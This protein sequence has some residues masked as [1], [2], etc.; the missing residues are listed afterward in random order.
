MFH[1]E[2]GIKLTRAGLALDFRRRQPRAFI[3]HAHF[4]HMARHE[5]ALCTPATGRLYQH[6]LGW[7]AGLQTAPRRRV[8]ELPYG[9]PVDFGGLRLT[10]FP[11]GHCL[12]S[13]ML[14]VE[15]GEKR[16]LY[17]G[18][19]KLGPSATAE[20]AVL[21][22][23]DVLIMESTF[24]RPQFRM[25]PR[26]QAIAALVELVRGTLFRGE[27]PVLH[28]YPMGKSQEISRILNDH[29]IGVLQHPEIFAITRVYQACGVELDKTREYHRFPL[30]G[31]AV[32]TLPKSCPRFRLPG[33]ER[34]V[35]IAVTGWAGCRSLRRLGVD[36]A[37]PLSDHAD[38]DELIEAV[39]LVHPERVFCTHGPAEFVDDL[40]NAGWDAQRLEWSSVRAMA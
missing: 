26:A 34:T 36:H 20:P 4:D 15:D 32:I 33:L 9:K 25:P 28:L 35:S 19:F 40:R 16:L 3:S 37:V 24:G 5:L 1:I 27:V 2:N 31:C 23:A 29:G 10:T 18:D 30:P 8:L 21:P 13:A 17:T 6:R 39:R 7:R 14:L 12:G 11:A 38:Y 22:P